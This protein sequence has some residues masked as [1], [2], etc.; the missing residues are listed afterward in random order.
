MKVKKGN[1]EDGEN[2]GRGFYVDGL[3]FILEVL[4]RV[5]RCILI[6][7]PFSRFVLLPEP[8]TAPAYL[9]VAL[10][11]TH[12]RKLIHSEFGFLPACSSFQV[13]AFERPHH[14]PCAVCGNTLVLFCASQRDQGN[15]HDGKNIVT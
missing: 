12:Q 10:V 3:I 14:K 7:F 2:V 11:P 4:T 9:S 8:S 1:D 13:H 5:P 15:T 6:F